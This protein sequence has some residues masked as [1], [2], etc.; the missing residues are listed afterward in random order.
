MAEDSGSSADDSELLVIAAPAR[1]RR[2]LATDEMRRLVRALCQGRFLT[3]RQLASL[4]NREPAGLQ[5][6][7]LRPMAAENQLVMAYPETPNHPK[8]AYMA[9]PQ[10][11][12]P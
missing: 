3:F 12:E 8:Q 7:T 9:N 6:W 10:W 5:R 11:N 4:L 2:R 1:Q